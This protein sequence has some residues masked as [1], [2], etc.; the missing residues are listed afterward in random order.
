MSGR[1][2]RSQVARALLDGARGASW[3][4]VSRAA[5]WGALPDCV[6]EGAPARG[7]FAGIRVELPSAYEAD[8]AHWFVRS[9]ERG[10]GELATLGHAPIPQRGLGIAIARARRGERTLSF[11]IDFF[12]EP[13]VDADVAAEV[14]LY[15]KLQFIRGGYPQPNVVPGGYVQPRTEPHDHFCR[16]RKYGAAH[17][18]DRVYGRFGA[19]Y[20]E[21][22]RR[23]AV[24][25]LEG[26]P[27]L[28]YRGGMGIVP[29]VQSLQE[30]AAAA[31]CVDL[32]GRGPFCYRLVDYFAVG[33]CVVA[34]PH[35]TRMPVE[36]EDRVNIVLAREDL[37]DLP[38]LCEWLLEDEPAR[39]RIGAAAGEYFDRHLHYLPLAGLY[40]RSIAAALDGAPVAQ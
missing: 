14:D 19:T 40:L 13:V 36:L 26:R 7:S 18:G 9:I 1:A 11:A 31:V 22:P 33:A 29:Y 23:R 28:G 35:P 25:L 16:L 12:D 5:L 17:P 3:G 27:A 21:G 10:L 2:S 4:S 37:S 38:D 8:D 34:A 24:E 39:R 6:P 30:A 15:F 20:G 32:P